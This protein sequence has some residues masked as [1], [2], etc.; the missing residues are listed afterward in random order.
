[1][2]TPVEDLQAEV[3]RLPPEKRARLLELLLASF[4]PRSNAQR[5]WMDL[6]RRRRKDV[7]SGKAA[8]VP[9]DE[10]MARVRTRMA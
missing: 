1:M 4:E 6:G 9:G 10:A 8:M 3:L 2:S 7:R 5:A